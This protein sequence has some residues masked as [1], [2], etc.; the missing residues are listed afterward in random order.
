MWFTKDKYFQVF[1]Y[2][3]NP[4]VEDLFVPEVNF[5]LGEPLQSLGRSQAGV[6]KK[7]SRRM[8][9]YWADFAKHDDPN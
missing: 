4:G 8:I 6:E 1:R 2:F 7:L 3:F 9:K 5:V